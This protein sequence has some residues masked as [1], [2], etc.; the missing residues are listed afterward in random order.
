[1]EEERSEEGADG[2][3]KGRSVRKGQK[4]GRREEGTEGRS[5]GREE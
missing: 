1:M 2:R 3:G 4:K 5:G